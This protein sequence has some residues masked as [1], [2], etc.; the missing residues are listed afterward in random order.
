MTASQEIDAS[1]VGARLIGLQ[2][3]LNAGEHH[4]R[5]WLPIFVVHKAVEERAES[6][7]HRCVL[8]ADH[9]AAHHLRT[10]WVSTDRAYQPDRIGEVGAEKQEI[11]IASGNGVN[12]RREI[13]SRERI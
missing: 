3:L 9:P 7:F 1:F 12:N 8:R 6:G 2:E 5:G 13:L 11:A 10:E 4:P